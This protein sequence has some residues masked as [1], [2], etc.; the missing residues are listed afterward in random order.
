MRSYTYIYSILIL[1]FPFLCQAQNSKSD[2][3]KNIVKGVIT[4]LQTSEPV[5]F[6]VISV[7]Q[8]TLTFVT[9]EDGKFEIRGLKPGY[10]TIYVQCEGYRPIISES[11][12]VSSVSPAVVNISLEQNLIEASEVIVTLSPFRTSS[13]APV[14]MRRIGSEEIDLTPGA[15]RDISKVVQL[16]PGVV[17]VSFGNRNDV[18][19]RGGGANENKYY[20]DGIEIPVLNHFSVQGGSGGYASLV[21]TD[22]LK[23]VNFYTGAFP[24]Q[25]ANG[26]SSVMD[27]EMKDGNSDKFH[28]KFILGATDA[29][30]NIDTP[31]SK[32]GKTTLV[33]S[34]RYSY[35]QMLFDI[36]GLPFLP[37]Y[38]DYQFKLTSKLSDK[39][40]LYFIGLGSFDTNV[41]NL[42]VENPTTSQQY[43]LGYL[44]NNDQQSNVFG[45]GYKRLFD[46]GALRFTFS[47][48]YLNNLLY[49]Y[50]DNDETLPKTLD[51]KTKEVD[52][53]FNSEIKLR[54]VLGFSFIGGL[55]GSKGNMESSTYQNVYSGNTQTLYDYENDLSIWRYHVYASFSRSFFENKLNTAFSARADGLSYS[56]NTNNLFKQVSPRF[57]FSYKAASR[58]TINGSVGRYY[59]EPTY[60]MMGY[61]D[62]DGSEDTQQDRLEYIS[63]NSYVLGVAYAPNTNSIIKAEG[64]YKQ[65]DNMPISLLDSLPVSTGDFEDYIVGNVP[66]AS[67]GEGRAYGFE[68][69]YRNLDFKNTVINI[70]FTHMYSQVN[71]MDANLQPI[72]G[73]YSST[74][75]DVRNI[76][77]ITAIHKLRNNWSIGGKWYITG[78]LPYT[79]YDY[80]L[81][82]TIEAWDATGRP[83]DDN[84]LYNTERSKTYHQL[85]LRV[86]KMWFFSK[87]RLGLYLD[88]QNVYNYSAETQSYLYPQTDANGNYVVDPD[89]PGYYLMETSYND[90]GGTILP[91]I[92]ITIEF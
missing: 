32:N 19:V 12:M 46:K 63:V 83:Y 45:V 80:D 35:F 51:I 75:W 10:N 84:T 40:E 44:P 5:D 48:N 86:D 11:F 49:K 27:M 68:L 52:Y 58:F 13:E 66:I 55:G 90:Y 9:Q 67:V 6:A 69:S 62:E 41:L 85:D 53:R 30:I 24:S 7:I 16:A 70:S 17:P 72:K 91:T 20:L 78:G 89:K 76:A 36:L 39:D 65:Y 73:Q 8:D 59:Q 88:I 38:N 50:E 34:Y 81:S 28:A 26:L 15:N 2:L 56:S 47:R 1:L 79:P 77:N 57:S 22:L 71:K 54:N 25:F 23:T 37:T 61:K 29:G 4:N 31:L 18:L 87:W 42:S 74:S 33:A 82:S 92:G 64:F 3:S 43:I 60:T 14:S 21:N